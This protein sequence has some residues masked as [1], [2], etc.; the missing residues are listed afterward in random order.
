MPN[1]PVPASE[2]PTVIKPRKLRLGLFGALAGIAAGALLGIGGGLYGSVAG[3]GVGLLFLGTLG[4][5]AE[6][7][8][9]AMCDV[10]HSRD[11]LWPRRSIGNTIASIIMAVL[12]VI[13]CRESFWLVNWNAAAAIDTAGQHLSAQT[14]RT[15]L[16]NKAQKDLQLARGLGAMPVRWMLENKVARELGKMSDVMEAVLA[17]P[18]ENFIS[19]NLRRVLAAHDSGPVTASTRPATF[20]FARSVL[21]TDLSVRAHELGEDLGRE[22]YLLALLKAWQEERDEPKTEGTAGPNGR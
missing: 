11:P 6:Q 22:K 4:F 9:Q 17:E 15:E 13:L 10:R 3:G 18:G 8:I 14:D 7:I 2:Q 1:E 21:G 16:T 19:D 5:V 12:L 20:S